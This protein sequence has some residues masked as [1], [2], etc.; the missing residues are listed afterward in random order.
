MDDGVRG[1]IIGVLVGAL[2]ALLFNPPRSRV[3]FIRRALASIFFGWAFG[4]VP[5]ATF[6][7]EPTYDNIVASFTVAAFG[8]WAAMGRITKYVEDFK[9]ET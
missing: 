2:L 5:L 7:I 3:G 6:K 1:K 9:K 8:A 4:H